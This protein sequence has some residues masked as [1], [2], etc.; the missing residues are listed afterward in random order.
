MILEFNQLQFTIGLLILID[1][2]NR[3]VVLS[4]LKNVAHD[5]LLQ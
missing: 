4:D 2:R 1:A 3:A 5:K